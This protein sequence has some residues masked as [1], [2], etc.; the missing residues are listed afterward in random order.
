MIARI[1]GGGLICFV[2]K[3]LGNWWTLYMNW[4]TGDLEKEQKFVVSLYL[5]L[6][7]ID[8]LV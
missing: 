2:F 1:T 7:S 3:W 4:P 6:D 5:R 8:S